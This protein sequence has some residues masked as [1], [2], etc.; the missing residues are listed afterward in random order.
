MARNYKNIRAWQDARKLVLE[1]YKF[2]KFFPKEEL[3][4]I[5]SQLRRSAISVTANI[6]EGSSRQHKKDYLNFLFNAKASLSEL[7]SLI[8]ISKD[9]DYL[10]TEQFNQLDVLCQAAARSLYGLIKSVESEAVGH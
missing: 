5:T 4:G 9:L 6:V 10:L 7:E 2:T 1:I 8:G 3:Y